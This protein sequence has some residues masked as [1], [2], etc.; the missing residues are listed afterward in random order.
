[1]QKVGIFAVA[2]S[3]GPDLVLEQFLLHKFIFPP[4]SIVATLG[5]LQLLKQVLVFVDDLG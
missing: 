3:V 5:V 4:V 2:V 1:M